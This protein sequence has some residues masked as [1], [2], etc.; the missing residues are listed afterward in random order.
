[1][2]SRKRERIGPTRNAQ[3]PHCTTHVLQSALAASGRWCH[4]DAEHIHAEVERVLAVLRSH[5]H[6]AVFDPADV[7]TD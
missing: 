5:G 7:T 4:H 6:E 3:L 2:T 1:M